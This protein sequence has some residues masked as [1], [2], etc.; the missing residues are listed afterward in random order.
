MATTKRKPTPEEQRADR[1]I[2]LDWQQQQQAA[3]EA[4]KLERQAASDA[5]LVQVQQGRAA[6]AAAVEAGT[7]APPIIPTVNEVF[8]ASREAERLEAEA[9]EAARIAALTPREIWLS[10]RPLSERQRIAK[11]EEINR[12]PYPVPVGQF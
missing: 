4:E 8:L 7:Y 10:T 1:L 9:T 3:F 6:R 12:M 2:A 11:W 5:F